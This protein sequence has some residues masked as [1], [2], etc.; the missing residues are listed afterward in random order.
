LWLD[1]V[2]RNKLWLD[3]VKGREAHDLGSIFGV[4]PHIL[5]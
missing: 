3:K 5:M 2:K 4:D 1:K